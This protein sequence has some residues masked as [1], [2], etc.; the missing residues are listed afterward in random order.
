VTNAIVLGAGRPAGIA[1]EIGV[2]VG[3]ADG[4]IDIRDADVLIGTS[5]GSVVAAQLA[6]G[7]TFDR[8]FD[9][10]TKPELRVKELEPPVRF[11]QLRRD[12][13][14]AK[15]AAASATRSG[16]RSARS[17]RRPGPSGATA[18]D[19]FPATDGRMAEA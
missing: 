6:S 8:S 10:Q 15:E 18:R 17:P 1:W 2:A 7:V 11:N 9:E 5:A 3:L 14:T 16:G 19:R 12:L 13:A 4:G